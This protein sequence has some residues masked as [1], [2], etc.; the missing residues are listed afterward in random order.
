MRWL[1]LYVVT[2]FLT[3]GQSV[4]TYVYDGL[5][6]RT[7]GPEVETRGD[8][9]TEMLQSINGRRVPVEKVEERVLRTEG[10]TKVVE[11]VIKRFDS[12]GNLSQTERVLEE[13]TAFPDGRST[14]RATTYRSDVSGNFQPVERCLMETRKSG[15]V[16]TLDATVDRPTI[17]GEFQTAEKLTIVDD[18][19][20]A[21]DVQNTTVYRPNDSGGF[22]E[23]MK[24]T[25]ERQKTDGQSVENTAKYAVGSSGRLE[26]YS[27]TVKTAVKRNDGAES[28]VTDVYAEQT[29]GLANANGKL[30]LKEEQLINRQT[31]NGEVNE[32]V[33]VRQPSPGDPDR[34]GPPRKIK[35]TICKGQC[36]P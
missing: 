11:R 18:R 5:G 23:A 17:N 31:R 13:Q 10:A 9:R 27:Q 4:Q 7:R 35:E 32:V 28:I 33:S 22:Y 14:V 26:L 12:N 8:S 20:A 36:A 29:P 16:I 6:N 30:R 24:S 15:T 25:L 3:C 1:V 21:R 2:S 34:L 19:S